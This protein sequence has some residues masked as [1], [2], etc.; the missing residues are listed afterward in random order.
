MKALAQDLLQQLATRSRISPKITAMSGATS[1]D[2]YLLEYPDHKEVLRV[3]RA[4]RWDT[5]AAE[6]SE[7]ESRILEAL[8]RTSLPVSRPLGT[9][10]GNGV[11]MS[12]L[13][14]AVALP[15]QPDTAWLET[16]ARSL[17]D[18]HRSG[19]EVPYAYES[20]NQ[21]TATECPD[22]WQERSLW[23]EAQSRSAEAPDFV[24]IFIHRDYHPV[25]VLWQEGRISGIVDWINACMGPAGIDVAHCRL[26]LA[27]MYGLEA[28]QAFLAAY[29]HAAPG[30]QHHAYWD[31]DDALGALPD[32]QVYP[33]W[34]EFGLTGLTTEMV[35]ERLQ[36]MV[37]ASV[38]AY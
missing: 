34:A 14:G 3:F 24:P 23:A 22:W 17:A 30:Y 10:T 1:S 12:W 38:E 21:T 11:L 36:A 2:L 9:L 4:E 28:A 7:R 18:I 31:L 13:P 15:K 26:N 8:T 32:V 33:P 19:I 35:R 37:S 27:V 16:L 5:P 25:N 6:L 20:W 29:L